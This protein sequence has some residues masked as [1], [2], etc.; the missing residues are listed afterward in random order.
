MAVFLIDTENTNSL[1]STCSHLM[2][3]GDKIILFYS[4]MSGKMSFSLFDA[5]TLL[6]IQVQFVKCVNGTNSALDFQLVSYLGYLISHDSNQTYY[7]ISNDN[8]YDAVI[9]FWQSRQVSILRIMFIRPNCPEIIKF[10]ENTTAIRA[11]MP[12]K[13][14]IIANIKSEFENLLQGQYTEE[15]ASVF[16]LFRSNISKQDSLHPSIAFRNALTKAYGL[17]TGSDIYNILKPVIA[18]AVKSLLNSNNIKAPE[19]APE[20]AAIIQD[21]KPVKK[22][23]ES[24]P[25]LRK[26]SDFTAFVNRNPIL[27]TYCKS[28]VHDI[29]YINTEQAEQIMAIMAYSMMHIKE[30]DRISRVMT[31]IKPIL[32]PKVQ[33]NQIDN[34]RTRL[35]RK[36]KSGIWPVD[37]IAHET[38]SRAVFKNKPNGL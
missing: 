12:V 4:E 6:D 7:I 15:A 37:V 18:P 22:P 8:G 32:S 34:L 25:N 20:P 1:W 23:P 35:S 5:I 13:Y 10:H 38:W 29:S 31:A 24:D 28:L 30:I 26:W 16:E 14:K 2:E 17:T 3:P 11:D 27:S 19:P 33:Q 36:L 9:D 21:T